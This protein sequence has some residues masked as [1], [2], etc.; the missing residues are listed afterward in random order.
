MTIIQPHGHK[1][2]KQHHS[3]GKNVRRTLHTERKR[4]WYKKI[5]GRRKS[6]I[7]KENET[8]VAIGALSG[9]LPAYPRT[10]ERRCLKKN[11][12]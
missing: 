9:P 5:L 4:K 2:E 11:V 12:L 7:S 8:R 10:T 3:E 1:I 6:D